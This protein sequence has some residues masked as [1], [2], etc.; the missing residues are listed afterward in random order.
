MRFSIVAMRFNA[1]GKTFVSHDAREKHNFY[2]VKKNQG[3]VH[4]F[5]L[6]SWKMK[7]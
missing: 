4:I 5:W 7:P 1:I 3:K 6:K 2:E